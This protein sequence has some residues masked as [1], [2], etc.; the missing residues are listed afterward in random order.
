MKNSFNGA[1]AVFIKIAEER[2]HFPSVL[3]KR[4]HYVAVDDMTSRFIYTGGKRTRKR[5]FLFNECEHIKLSIIPGH[6]LVQINRFELET[7]K[8]IPPLIL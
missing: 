5:I 4:R 3:M 6:C 8:R 1:G 7:G 2:R